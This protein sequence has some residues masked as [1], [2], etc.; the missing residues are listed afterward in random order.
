MQT[1]TR[2]RRRIV[3]IDPQMQ[4]D[5]VVRSVVVLLLF[6]G[7]VMGSLFYTI[8][9]YSRLPVDERLIHAT[10]YATITTGVVLVLALVATACYFILLSHRVAGPAYRLKKVLE[11]L[12]GGDTTAR[13]NLRRGDYLKDVAA[14]VNRLAEDLG[15]RRE[16]RETALRH[17]R[18]LADLVEGQEGSSPKARELVRAAID[19]L[20]GP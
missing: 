6:A 14:Q 12:Q 16:R 13:A 4:S 10:R 11:A 15:A 20:Q 18:V 5:F 3:V 7:C 19:A 1:T 2:V 17:M 9:R 8:S